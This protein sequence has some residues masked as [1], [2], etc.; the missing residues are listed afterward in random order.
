MLPFRLP[1]SNNLSIYHQYL[2]DDSI[3]KK[4]GC[5]PV[6]RI[7]DQDSTKWQVLLVQSRLTP[8]VWLFPKGTIED[9]E[10]G[11]NAAIRETCEEGGVIGDLGPKLGTW[12]CQR[13]RKQKQKMWL[14]FV[15]TEYSND[16]K[17]WKERKKRLRAWHSFEEARKVLTDIPE[18]TQRPELMDMLNA[19]E[20]VCNEIGTGILPLP[21]KDANDS[22]D[23]D[24]KLVQ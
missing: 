19:A 7:G 12:V 13:S 15:T 16:S 10:N 24:D 3:A 2:Y 23:E 6:R 20:N 8:E 22:G 14:L 5:V 9:D 21:E 11:K 4:A 18:D 1:S 17:L